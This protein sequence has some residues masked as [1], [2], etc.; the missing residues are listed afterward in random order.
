MENNINKECME[1]ILQHLKKLICLTEFEDIK[2]LGKL[3]DMSTSVSA[4]LLA[5]ERLCETDIDE[6]VLQNEQEIR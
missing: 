4:Q 1:E 3:V 6:I 2:S 5:M